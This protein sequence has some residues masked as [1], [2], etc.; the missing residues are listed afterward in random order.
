MRW[1]GLFVMLRKLGIS[2]CQNGVLHKVFKRYAIFNGAAG[3]PSQTQCIII[4]L[5]L[6]NHKIQATFLGS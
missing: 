6:L 5:P 2:I 4:T 1:S 3:E